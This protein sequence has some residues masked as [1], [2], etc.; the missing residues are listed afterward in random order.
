MVKYQ[1]KM[2]NHGTYCLARN[3]YRIV[4]N[5]NMMIENFQERRG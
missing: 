5:S 3:V 1:R 4:F 2:N